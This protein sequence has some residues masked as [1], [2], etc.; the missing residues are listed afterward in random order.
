MELLLLC[1]VASRSAPG[2]C[3]HRAPPHLQ[4]TA[5][6]P[7]FLR[8]LL[9][10]APFLQHLLLT[11]SLSAKLVVDISVSST[12]VFDTACTSRLVADVFFSLRLV[13]DISPCSSTPAPPQAQSVHTVTRIQLR[14]SSP[15][16]KVVLNTTTRK[17]LI[18]PVLAS[19]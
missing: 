9:L 19:V 6:A 8:N 13:V 4:A 11:S 3:R 18:L 1:L 17:S 14:E 2:M 16:T 7:P 10:T 15:K 12:L 5:Q